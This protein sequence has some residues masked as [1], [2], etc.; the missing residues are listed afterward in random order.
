MLELNK[1]LEDVKHIVKENIEA[2]L[3]REGTLV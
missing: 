1:E 3:E 2:I